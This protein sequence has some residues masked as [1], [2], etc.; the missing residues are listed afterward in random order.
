MR[1][2]EVQHLSDDLRRGIKLSRDK[3]FRHACDGNAPV[4]IDE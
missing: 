3:R 1:R 2:Y 4:E